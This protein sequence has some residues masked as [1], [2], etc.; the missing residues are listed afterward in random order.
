LSRF[1]MD[2]KKSKQ[3]TKQ[4]GSKKGRVADGDV[5]LNLHSQV[6]L[7]LDG[8]NVR[9]LDIALLPSNFDMFLRYA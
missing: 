6:N 9:R 8:L 2:R 3:S 1:G 4:R 5:Q 7:T